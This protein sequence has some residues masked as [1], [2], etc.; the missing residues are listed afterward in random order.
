MTP[1]NPFLQ[2]L[3]AEPDDDTLRLALADWLTENDQP[4]RAE[5]I[6]VQIEL[7]CGVSDLERRRELEIRQ[8][9]LLIAH[10]VQWVRPLAAVLGCKP[11]QWGGWVFRRGFVE[12]FH[13]PA[14]VINRRGTQLTRLTP[15]RE[16]FLRPCTPGNITTMCQ[17]PWLHSVIALYI[18]S[19]PL[20]VPA[21]QAL[22]DCPF[23]T[24]LRALDVVLQ[25]GLP[26]WSKNALLLRFAHALPEP[27]VRALRPPPPSDRMGP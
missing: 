27:T 8:R 1:D 25:D 24:N 15:V 19:A 22:V 14:S 10:E 7:A 16:L 17:R 13:L 21:V 4:E 23:L 6:R 20:N 5:F 11:G 2:A 9:D 3:L 12:Y 26:E 18:R